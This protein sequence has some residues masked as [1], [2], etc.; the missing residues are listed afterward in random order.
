MAAKMPLDAKVVQSALQAEPMSGTE[1]DE[2]VELVM[3]IKRADERSRKLELASDAGKPAPTPTELK[4]ADD[5]K[6]PSEVFEYFVLD[7]AA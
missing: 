4:W 5:W 6:L 1:R 2:I 3:R 7:Q